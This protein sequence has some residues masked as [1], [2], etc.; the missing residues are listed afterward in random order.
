MMPLVFAASFDEGFQ[1]LYPNLQDNPAAAHLNVAYWLLV[2]I[3]EFVYALDFVSVEL[4]FRGFLVIGMIKV[5]GRGAIVP[6]AVTY[7]FYH[8]GK[9]PGETIN[10]VFGGYILG[11]I[12]LYT[13]SIL[14]GIIV[15]IGIAWM[16]EFFA[17]MQKY[18]PS[19]LNS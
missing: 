18:I 9:P 19:H 8:F 11:V 5:L 4:I 15:H 1:N 13:R 14:G 17:Y 6:M 10:S 2:I 12:A 3:F 7:A 16:M